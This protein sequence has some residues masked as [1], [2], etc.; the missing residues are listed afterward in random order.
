MMANR[1]VTISMEQNL[2]DK[3]DAYANSLGVSRTASISFLVV[4]G[5]QVS[6]YPEMLDKLDKIGDIVKTN[7][8]AE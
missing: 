2:L 5:L 8:I 4:Q 7:Q 3:V 1:K 6:L